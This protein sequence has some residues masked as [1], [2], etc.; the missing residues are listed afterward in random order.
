VEPR[1]AARGVPSHGPREG[2]LGGLARARPRRR[3]GG[4]GGGGGGW[5]RIGE[6]RGEWGNGDAAALGCGI[7]KNVGFAGD[8]EWTD[9][10]L[11]TVGEG[12]DVWPR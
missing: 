7:L 2:L 4:G 5:D 8:G 9:M 1:A 6:G 12:R 10:P 3:V 11:A